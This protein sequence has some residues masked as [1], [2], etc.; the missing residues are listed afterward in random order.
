MCT[1]ALLIVDEVEWVER[2]VA[3]GISALEVWCH[4][5]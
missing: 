3:D 1:W 2:S 4:I 5:I